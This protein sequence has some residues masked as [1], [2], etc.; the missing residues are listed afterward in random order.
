MRFAGR[1]FLAAVLAMGLIAAVSAGPAAAQAPGQVTGLSVQQE[2]GFATL[3]WAPVA[4]ATTYQ[5][6]RTPA[7]APLGTGV[8]VGVW[9]PNRQVNQDSPAFA[10][11]GFNPGDGFQWRVRARTETA[12]LPYSEPVSGTTRPEF[13]D[14][15]T[16]GENLRTQWEETNAASF[17]N[18]V[19]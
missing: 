9:R 18:D 13:G 14:P 12:E 2:D 3:R 11:A 6:E 16:P 5:I 8:V 1:A 4:G 17:T 10:D 7:G 15:A 19:N